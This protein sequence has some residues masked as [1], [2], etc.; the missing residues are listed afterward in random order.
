[1]NTNKNSELRIWNLLCLSC[2]TFSCSY[3]IFYFLL[4]FLLKNK[5]TN[6]SNMISNM[7]SFA[8]SKLENIMT[9]IDSM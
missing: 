2:S 9:K 1:M 6:E 8:I 5:E 4:N 7:A 3:E